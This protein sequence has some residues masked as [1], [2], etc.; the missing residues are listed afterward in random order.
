MIVTLDDGSRVRADA[1]V[2]S[3]GVRP[4][5]G[6]LR[7]SGISLSNGV[8]VDSGMRMLDHRGF[9]AAGDLAA[10]PGPG[11][12]PLRTEHWGAALAH[13][14]TAAASVLADLGL[15]EAAGGAVSVEPPGYS[16][17]VHGTKLTMVGSAHDAVG[18][19]VVHGAVGEERFTVALLDR[20]GR[21]SAAVGV[22]GAR[23][24]NR[25]RGLIARR[26]EIGEVDQVLAEAA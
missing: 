18:E 5:V 21:I 16:T 11:G 19:A 4:A 12:T 3:L 26:G 20:D 17:Y 1:V 24:A 14:R 22:G 7:A 2:A 13:G 6:W 9:Y 23:I 15:A 8:S 10:V 25:L